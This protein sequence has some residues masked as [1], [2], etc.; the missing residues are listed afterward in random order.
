VSDSGACGSKGGTNRFLNLRQFSPTL[1]DTEAS[2][3]PMSVVGT[4]MKLDER[5]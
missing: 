4:R 2:M 1:M 5:R 3:S